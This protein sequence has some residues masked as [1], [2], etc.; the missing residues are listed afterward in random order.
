VCRTG[1]A[2]AA[3]LSTLDQKATVVV[4]PGPLVADIPPADVGGL[5]A[6]HD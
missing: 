5:L 4:D 2:L 3:W 6:H 1:P